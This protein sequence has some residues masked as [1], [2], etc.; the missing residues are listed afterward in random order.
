MKLN[1]GKKNKTKIV[2]TGIPY[3]YI[4]VGNQILIQELESPNDWETI[5]ESN[6]MVKKSTARDS[7]FYKGKILMLGNLVTTF[8]TGDLI[9]Y[10]I[11]EGL[12][13]IQKIN[14]N[15]YTLRIISS[16]Y[17]IPITLKE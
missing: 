7:F 15:L 14:G 10:N 12:R 1:K 11:V 8:Q 17:I 3:L 2:K 9:L 6:I 16:Q 13:F 4:P 5:G